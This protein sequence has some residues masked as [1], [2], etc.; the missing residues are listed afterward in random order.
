MHR[1]SLFKWRHFFISRNQIDKS[2][3][4]TTLEKEP[5]ARKWN[6]NDSIGAMDGKHVL[7]KPPAHSGSQ[8]FNY[9]HTFTIVLLAIVDADYKFIFADVGCNGR[10]SNGGV[11]KN[12]SLYQALEDKALKIPRETLLPGTDQCFPHVIVADD[13]F[14][15]KVYIM[16]LY[17]QNTLKQEKRLFNYRLS[18][19]RRVVENAFGIL[20]NRFRIFMTRMGLVPEKV[21][22]ITLACC[23]LHNFLQ[24]KVESQSIYMPP[25][26][27]DTEDADTHVFCPREWHQGP[28]PTGLQPLAQQGS[29]R[30]SNST[31]QVHDKL[32]QYFFIQIKAVYHGSGIWCKQFTN[33]TLSTAHF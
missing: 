17:S 4:S 22:V 23:T 25:R 29:N 11:L 20:P 30:H 15:L 2:I 13:A 14:P 3:V 9:K 16:K 28:T 10:I 27:I 5:L 19:A 8:Y 32:C 18:R 24:P 21:E 31:K 1:N 26:S 6:F 12:C 33:S 7:L